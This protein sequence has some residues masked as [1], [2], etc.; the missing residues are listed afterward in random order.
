MTLQISHKLPTAKEYNELRRLVEWPTY[1]EQLV[2]TALRNS[3]FSVVV[4]DAEGNIL[5]MGRVLGDNAIY[6]HVQDVIV[7]PAVQGAG[8]GKMIMKEIL[9]FVEGAGHS[10]T[11]VGLMSSKGR[12]AFYSLFGFEQ[13][14]SERFG[15]G[16]IKILT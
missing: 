11:N 15:A 7:R 10:N 3:L 12:E 14:P 16:M 1:D 5:G 6:F 13:R 4:H 2:D 9:A 8:I